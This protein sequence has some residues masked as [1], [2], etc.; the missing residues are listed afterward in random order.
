LL[1]E[2]GLLPTQ[3]LVARRIEIGEHITALY[4]AALRHEADQGRSAS[5]DTRRPTTSDVLQFTSNDRLPG[6]LKPPWGFHKRTKVGPSYVGEQISLSN[7]SS[8]TKGPDPQLIRRKRE[9]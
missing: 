2:D 6:A 5:A 9:R 7:R 1:D 3:F 8:I 4:L